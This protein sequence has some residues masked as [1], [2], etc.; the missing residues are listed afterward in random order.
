MIVEKEL[1]RRVTD[2]FDA[3]LERPTGARRA[4]LEEACQG[5]DALLEEVSRLLKEFERAGSFLEGPV[6]QARHAFTV[7]QLV[8]ARYRIEALP[9]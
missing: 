2:L 7:G 5:D 6:F 3:A 9:L 8:T 1:W 4:Y